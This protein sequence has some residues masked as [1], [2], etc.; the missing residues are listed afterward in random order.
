MI[1]YR[2]GLYERLPNGEHNNMSAQRDKNLNDLGINFDLSTKGQ[3]AITM[4]YHIKVIKEF[5]G[6][7]RKLTQ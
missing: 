1:N 4:G 2:R 5:H 6:E 7:L 3:V